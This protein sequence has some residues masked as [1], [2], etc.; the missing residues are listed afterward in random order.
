MLSKLVKRYF[1]LSYMFNLLTINDFL[2]GVGVGKSF[3]VSKPNQRIPPSSYFRKF[4]FHC[5]LNFT[6][7]PLV[8]LKSPQQTYVCKQVLKCKTTSSSL[9]YRLCL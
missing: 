1:N 8:F 9:K 3:G 5:E 7:L 2:W 6:F 4:E